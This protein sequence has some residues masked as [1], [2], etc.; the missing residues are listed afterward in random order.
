[1]NFTL[2]LPTN[3][4]NHACNLYID[5]SLYKS[6]DHLLSTHDHNIAEQHFISADTGD[7][8]ST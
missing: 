7:K 3:P 4:V 2:S 6:T 1:M 8:H 5:K